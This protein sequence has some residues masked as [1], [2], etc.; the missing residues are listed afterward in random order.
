MVSFITGATKD[1]GTAL[2]R[3]QLR[4][5][6]IENRL[7][8]LSTCLVESV[9]APIEN[10]LEDWKKSVNQLDKDHAKGKVIFTQPS[11]VPKPHK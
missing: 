11:N 3:L 7:K 1:I 8:S 9:A 2:T 6:N 10:K 4:H 5:K